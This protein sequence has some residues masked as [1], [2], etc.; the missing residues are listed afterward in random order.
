MPSMQVPTIK[1]TLEFYGSWQATARD[2]V[3]ELATARCNLKSDVKKKI[4]D[5]LVPIMD[6][7]FEIEWLDL[8]DSLKEDE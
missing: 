5:K 6:V 1:V 4:R 7:P 3:G 2:E 8:T